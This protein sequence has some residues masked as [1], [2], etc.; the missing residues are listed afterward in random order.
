MKRYDTPPLTKEERKWIKDLERVLLRAPP[1]LE[2]YTT[3]DQLV[4]S[5][6]GARIAG[7][8]VDFTPTCA[9]CRAKETV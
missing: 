9:R 6:T 7:A 4:N 8:M 3:A 2:L 5:P 1:R